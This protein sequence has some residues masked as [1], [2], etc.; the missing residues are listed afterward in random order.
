M[1][2]QRFTAALFAV[3]LFACG[4]AVGA[5][6]HRYFSMTTVSAR[7]NPD[8]FRQRYVKEMHERLKLTPDQ[9]TKLEAIMD[10]TKAKYRALRESNRPEMLK[11]K[12]DQIQAVKNILTAD[13]I[14]TYEQIVAEHERRVREEHPHAGD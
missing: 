10:N 5:L 1:K 9:L 2:G 4:V 8:L 12:Q 14:P 3:L 6:G 13:Q 11:I 7:N